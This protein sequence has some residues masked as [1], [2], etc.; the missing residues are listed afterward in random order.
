MYLFTTEPAENA[1]NLEGRPARAFQSSNIWRVREGVDLTTKPL[2]VRR[3]GR[4]VGEG[5]ALT[6]PIFSFCH[7]SA[8]YVLGGKQIPAAAAQL[9]NYLI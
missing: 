5:T 1:E 4:R 9:S 2:D 8:L 3:D 6:Y 7:L